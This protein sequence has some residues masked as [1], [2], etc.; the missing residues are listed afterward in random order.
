MQR[1]VT[2]YE[3]LRGVINGTRRAPGTRPDCAHIFVVD[4]CVSGLF[5]SA[6]VGTKPGATARAL[7]LAMFYAL[8]YGMPTGPTNTQ[9][10]YRQQQLV[11]FHLTPFRRTV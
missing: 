11:K 5:S 4:Y 8:A 3:G 6:D 2:R 1:L 7:A 10:N 9:V